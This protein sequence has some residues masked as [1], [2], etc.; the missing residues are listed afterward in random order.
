MDEESFDK[1]FSEKAE[2]FIQQYFGSEFWSGFEKQRK[3][4]AQKQDYPK[5]DLLEKE[6]EVIAFVELPGL[7]NPDD[8]VVTAN[9]TSLSLKGKL[10]SQIPP[11]S[12]CHLN[13][14]TET[15]FSREIALPAHID[16]NSLQGNYH[17]G[18][19]EIRMAKKSITTS[20]NFNFE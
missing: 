8:V 18:V 17:W 14:F 3:K 16:V 13:E 2:S 1:S 19:L 7:R 5:I 10:F 6:T 9:N 20:L 11:E 4:P 12:H 15:S